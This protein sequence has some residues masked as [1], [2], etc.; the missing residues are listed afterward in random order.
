MSQYYP[1]LQSLRLG[2]DMLQPAQIA[3]CLN[4]LES[5]IQFMLDPP[6][7]QKIQTAAIATLL[8]VL[9]RM[10]KGGTVLVTASTEE[11]VDSLLECIINSRQAFSNAA[12]TLGFTMPD[13][14]T[15]KVYLDV[16]ENPLQNIEVKDAASAAAMVHEY[17][18]PTIL[19]LAGTKR[20]TY[21]I[22]DKLELT[23]NRRGGLRAQLVVVNEAHLLT[24]QHFLILAFS[25]EPDGDMLVLS[26]SFDI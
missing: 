10:D 14:R 1:L 9:H 26:H 24:F 23:Y 22:S 4:R 5:R 7:S 6:S 12:S 18:D 8:R 25:T 19:M 17:S 2:E 15:V 16:P 21:E 20:A 13:I 3:A 11:A